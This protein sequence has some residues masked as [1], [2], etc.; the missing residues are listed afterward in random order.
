LS[1]LAYLYFGFW[2]VP[3]LLQTESMILA[4][5]WQSVG[6]LI[7]LIVGGWAIVQKEWLGIVAVIAVLYVEVRS[8]RRALASQSRP[9]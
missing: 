3:S 8:I 1:A 6:V 2:Q 4:V 5:L 9:Q 7:V